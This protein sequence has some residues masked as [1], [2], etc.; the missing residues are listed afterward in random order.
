MSNLNQTRAMLRDLLEK[1]TPGE[2]HGDDSTVLAHINS[3]RETH[4]CS[5]DENWLPGK[6]KQANA[7]L[8]RKAKNAL[9]ALLDRLDELERAFQRVTDIT[10]TYPD[11]AND[12]YVQGRRDAFKSF[13]RILNRKEPS[14]ENQR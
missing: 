10:A 2:W 13:L 11:D 5:T 14:H 6:E 12:P 1:A 4:I 3:E 9:P 7:E 8:I